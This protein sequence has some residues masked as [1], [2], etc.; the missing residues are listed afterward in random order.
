MNILLWHVHGSWTTAFVQGRHTYLVPVTPGRDPD[1]LGRARTFSWPESVLEA[2]PE[3]LR[4]AE[5][6]IVVLQRP[7]ELEL[8][9]RWLGGR[10]PG[11]DIP[12]VYLEHNAPDGD[13]P[14]TR[15]PFADRD[16]LTLVHV[17]HFNRLFWDCGSTR[18][19][20]IEHGIVDPGHLYTGHLPRAAVV[21]NEPVRRGRYTGTDLLSALCE[22]APLDVFG[23]RTEGLARRLGIPEELC[24]SADLPQRD[25]H[26]ALAHRRLYLHP[27]RWTS[28]GLSLLEAMHLGM[29]VV[30]LATTEAVEA[31]PAGTGVLST[32][33]E[34]L[35]RAMRRY[36]HEPEAAAEDGARGREAAVERY[37]LKRFLDDWEELITEVRS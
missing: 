5:I 24:R 14:D 19:R 30:A 26:A 37:G 7:H 12:A 22:T 28:L 11:R 36:L 27:V 8:A 25:L 31:V 3:Q 35:A 9:E 33:P 1:G 4:D 2:T 18:T 34:V 10:R 6:D 21:V 32:R 20:V 23:M 15:H 29:P 17:T 13:V 16:D